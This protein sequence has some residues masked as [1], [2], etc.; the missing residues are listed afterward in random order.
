M[1]F[2]FVII[3][4]F[5]VK[6]TPLSATKTMSF[7]PYERPFSRDG[8]IVIT[9]IWKMT[10]GHYMHMKMPYFRDTIPF[11]T[12]ELVIIYYSNNIIHT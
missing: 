4:L 7:L 2:E 5:S 10:T 3:I 1:R 6:G 12:K 8:G 9:G 11:K